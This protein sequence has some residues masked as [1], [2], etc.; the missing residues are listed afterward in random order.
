MAKLTGLPGVPADMLKKASDDY[1]SNLD[2]WQSA[3]AEKY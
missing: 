1:N 2:I 3:D